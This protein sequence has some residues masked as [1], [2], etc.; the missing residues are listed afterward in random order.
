M[1]LPSTNRSKP[2][3]HF[4]PFE[5]SLEDW[6]KVLE[7]FPD[8]ELF[9]TPA[10]LRFLAES[11]NA[12]PV[13][14]V[15]KEGN[16]AVGY[17]AGMTVRKFGLKILGSPFIGWTTER[18]GIRLAQG[19]PKR[20]AVE[21]LADYA[22]RDLR[23]VHLEFSDLQIAPTDVDGLGFE[24]RVQEGFVADLVPDE[25]QILCNMHAKSARYSIRK[26]AKMGVV[27][28]EAGDEQ[29]AEDYYY[30][31]REVFA[32]Q[33]LMPTYGKERTLLLMRHLLPTGN[34]LLLR[35]RAPDGRC[36][37]TG[38][39]LGMNRRAYFWGNASLHNDRHLCPNEAIHW[40]AM[41]YWKRQGMQC[42]DMCGAG[43]YKRKYGCRPFQSHFLWKSRSRWIGLARTIAEKSFFFR[44]KLVGR[45]LRKQHAVAASLEQEEDA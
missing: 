20:A 33:G 16:A 4:E 31:L 39:F 10:W 29:F 19:V 36:I 14:A 1:S 40:Y 18:M 2:L 3:L 11:Q 25:E 26:A 30:Q 8:R 43:M 17:F 37:A 45:L 7:T 5:G 28:E 21:A 24:N 32:Y 27:V 44:Q 6:G 9:Q 12:E 41:R 34:L 42:Y 13:I 35:A 23:C 15:L 38:I 22:F